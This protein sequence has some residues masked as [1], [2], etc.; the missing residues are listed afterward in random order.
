MFIAKIIGNGGPQ[1]GN[2]QERNKKA[3]NQIRK[4][5]ANEGNKERRWITRSKIK[6]T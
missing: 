1:R 2:N 5:I 4:Q 6:Q 3:K